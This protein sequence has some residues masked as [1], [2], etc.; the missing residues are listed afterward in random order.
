MDASSNIVMR[1]ARM[2][3]RQQKFRLYFDNYFTSFDLLK[4]FAKGS[5]VSL[6]TKRKNRI[7]DCKLSSEKKNMTKERG[8]SEEYVADVNGNDVLQLHGRQQNC[9]N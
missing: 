3:P 4:H 9:Q 7:P 5:N 1:L 8:Y 6:G 2:I